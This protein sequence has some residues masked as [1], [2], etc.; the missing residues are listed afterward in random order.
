VAEC[1]CTFQSTSPLDLNPN[2]VSESGPHRSLGKLSVMKTAIFILLGIIVLV[3]FSCSN[4]GDGFFARILGGKSG[5]PVTVESVAVEDRPVELRIPATIKQQELVEVSVPDEVI[6]ERIIA[7]EG[8]KINSGDPVA[9][10]SDSDLAARLARLRVDAKDAQAT[11]EKNNYFFANRDRLLSEGRIDQTQHDNLESEIAKNEAALEK[12]KQDITKYED[13]SSAP[14]VTSPATGTLF[15]INVTQGTTLTP[16]TSIA[17]VAKGEG[18]SLTFETTEN[19]AGK[20]RVGQIVKVLMHDISNMRTTARITAI[21]PTP[22]KQG[23]MS[24]TALLANGTKVGTTPDADVVTT[25]GEIQRIFVI[26]EEA[27]IR[28][29][30]AIFVFIVQKK[31]AHKVQVLPSETIGNR[32]EITRGLT[33]DSLVVVKGQDKL[34]EG[35]TVSVLR[36]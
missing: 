35:T 12:I 16:G 21:S 10:L 13:R 17:T 30:G 8:G 20:F 26:P 25:S 23:N 32:V 4:E 22:D 34:S 5:T 19:V 31:T 14:I 2:S 36:K 11:L 3:V 7:T 27:L 18:P 28:E 1:S 15:S 24:I 6:V 9:R 29:R 33:E